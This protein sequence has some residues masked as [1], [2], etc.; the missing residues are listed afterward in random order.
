MEVEKVKMRTYYKRHRIILFI[1]K[2][3]L[4]KEAAEAE[5]KCEAEAKAKAEAEATRQY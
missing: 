5:A 3:L 1:H 2:P 4:S